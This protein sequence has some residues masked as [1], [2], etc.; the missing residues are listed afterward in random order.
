MPKRKASAEQE[1]QVPTLSETVSSES[2]F[3]IDPEEAVIEDGFNVREDFGDLKALEKS[4]ECQGIVTP[5][6]GQQ[7]ADGKWVITDGERRVRAA[8][9]LKS[10][11]TVRLL[12]IIQEPQGFDEEKRTASLLSRNDGKE[13]TLLE[14]AAVVGRLMGM[15]LKAKTIGERVGKTV[16]AIRNLEKLVNIPDEVRDHIKKGTISASLV[17]E[18]I[19]KYPDPEEYTKKIEEGVKAAQSLE[20]LR[21]TKTRELLGDD[22]NS[23]EVEEKVTKTTTKTK[24]SQK[25]FDENF[26]K[27]KAEPKVDDLYE[28]LS[29]EMSNGKPV[30]AK[31]LEALIY[32]GKF[33]RGEMD[34]EEAKAFF[35]EPETAEAKV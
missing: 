10:K 30:N 5:L 16:T 17:I 3:H 25:D 2:L 1:E 31:M 35:Y 9:A 13:L 18:I 15:G 12:P 20:Q 27:K 34:I 22:V 32:A 23:I 14:Q 28:A 4:I 33:T 21:D 26:G 7:M 24:V 29:E 6:M 19:R 11:G 8:L